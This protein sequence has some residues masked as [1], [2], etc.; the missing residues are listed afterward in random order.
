MTLCQAHKVIKDKGI[1]PWMAWAILK[2]KDGYSI[3]GTRQIKRFPDLD[4]IYIRK[5]DAF[6][7]EPST[8]P[9]SRINKIIV[10]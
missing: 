1:T 10:K 3:C 2:G 5:G 8:L 6:P 4:Y 7:N 9:S